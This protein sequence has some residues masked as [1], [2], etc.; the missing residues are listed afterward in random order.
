MENKIEKE[1]ET[2]VE[3]FEGFF[4]HFT[5]NAQVLGSLMQSKTDAESQER[6]KNAEFTAVEWEHLAKNNVLDNSLK[7]T[8]AKILAILDLDKRIGLNINQDLK[9]KVFA[10]EGFADAFENY[11]EDEVFLVDAE[12]NLKERSTGAFDQFLEKTKTTTKAHY[13]QVRETIKKELE[14]FK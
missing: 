6:F 14:H 11:S 10:I 2:L 1:F 9:K 4:K 12:G 8:C 5:S 7:R 3:Q 13:K